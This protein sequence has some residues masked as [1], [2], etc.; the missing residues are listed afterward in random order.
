MLPETVPNMYKRQVR[1]E[2]GCHVHD[3][4]EIM[5]VNTVQTYLLLLMA[6]Y[7]LLA[8]KSVGCC[9]HCDP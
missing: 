6:L 3:Q 9:E 7:L 2:K 8:N 5:L 1:M 4:N